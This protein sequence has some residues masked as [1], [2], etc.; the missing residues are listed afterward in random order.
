MPIKRY[1]RQVTKK[2]RFYRKTK[3]YSKKN[4]SKRR[5]YSKKKYQKGGLF[6]PEESAQIKEKLIHIGFTDKNEINYIITNMGRMSQQFSGIYFEQLLH[7]MSTIDNPEEFKEWIER[8]QPDF[9]ENV[10]TDIED[11]D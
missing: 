9:E 4:I 7:Q 3:K 10:E 1:K 11:E 6:N 8:L 2:H 5:R